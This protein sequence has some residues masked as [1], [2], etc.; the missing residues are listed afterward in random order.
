MI[1]G[2]TKNIIELNSRGNDYY[3]KIIIILK[4]STA[5]PDTDDIYQYLEHLT[6]E[7]PPSVVKDKGHLSLKLLIAGVTGAVINTLVLLII[8]LFV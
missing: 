1:K 8:L 5:S 3:E 7:R 4:E 6:K 2:V